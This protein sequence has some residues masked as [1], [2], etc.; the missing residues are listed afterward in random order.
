MPYP[1]AQPG[2]AYLVGAGPGSLDYLTVRGQILLRQADVVVYDALIDPELLEMALTTC[3]LINVGKRG[4]QPSMKQTEIDRLLVHYCLAKK[5]VVRLKSGDP[6]I[7]GRTTSEIQALQDAGCEFEVVPGI[8]SA[9]AAPLLAG[10]PLTDPVLSRCFA[11]LS[12]HEPDALDW[13]SLVGIDTLVIL[14]GGQHLGTIVEQLQRHGRSPQTPVAILRWAGQPQSQTWIGTLE[15]I[16]L[17]TA[18]QPLSPAVITIGEVVRLRSYLQSPDPVVSITPP[19][20]HNKTGDPD[21]TGDPAPIFSSA[22]PLTVSQS[23]FLSPENLSLPLLN[24]TILVTRAAGQSSAFAQLLQQQGATVME[25]P[26]LEIKPPS[27]WDALDRA[28]AHLSNFHWL[29]LTSTNGVDYFFE[30]LNAQGNDARALAGIKIAVVGQK[31]AASLQHHGLNADFIP[32]SFVADAMVEQFPEPLAGLKVLFPRVETGGRDVLVQAFT[33]AKAAV[34]EVSAYQSCC[35]QVLPP[36]V[37]Q[38]LHRGQIDAITFASSK[39]VECFGHLLAMANDEVGDGLK[40]QEIEKL[41]SNT[42]IASIGPQTSAAC[43]K[44]FRRV[45]V[46]ADQY[47]LEGLVQALTQWANLPA[48][49]L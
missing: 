28:I 40:P 22:A 39:T 26:A 43:L 36:E 33:A 37:S 21:K 32:S 41:L 35:T 23:N 11:V 6:F 48:D 7:F 27:S 9:L 2:T 17:Q 47:T 31:T 30:R 46:E 19:I 13:Q 1:S 44:R 25:V 24:K 45:D 4:G 3:L 34:T 14:M 49:T 38:A 15:T 20:A 16:V 18:R 42:C 12:A 5:R 29:I 10:I 8:S